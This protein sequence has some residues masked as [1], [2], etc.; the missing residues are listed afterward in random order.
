MPRAV[1]AIEPEYF[2]VTINRVV[3]IRGHFYRPGR[4]VVDSATLAEL[5]DAVA[6]KRPV[7]G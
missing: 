3:E 5:G 1:K 6:S 4:H 7:E 2:E